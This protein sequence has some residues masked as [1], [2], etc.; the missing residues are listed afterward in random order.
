MKILEDDPALNAGWGAVLDREGKLELDAGIAD[1]SDR[2]VRRGGERHG[3]AS[4]QPGAKVME[5]TPHVLLTG[6]G[7][8]SLRALG[9]E[10]ARVVDTGAARTLGEGREAEGGL[11]PDRFGSPEYVD[12]VGALALDDYGGLAAGSSTGGVF[13]KMPGRVGRRSDLRCRDVRVPTSRR[14]GNRGR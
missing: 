9:M 2:P 10:I 8:A 11:D 14:D 6:A 7:R 12:T 13:G 3:P 1:G 5:E 4:D